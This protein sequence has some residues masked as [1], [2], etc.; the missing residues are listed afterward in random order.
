[1]SDQD[2]QAAGVEIPELTHDLGDVTICV[3]ELSQG[4]F[5]ASFRPNAT[6]HPARGGYTRTTSQGLKGKT[7][8]AVLERA[9]ADWR[10][11]YPR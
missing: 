10:Q 5:E 11:S 4:R 2:A 3:R 6:D 9:E 1:M 7:L 8:E